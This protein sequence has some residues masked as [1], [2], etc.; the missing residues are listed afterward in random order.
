VTVI[1]SYPIEM[2]QFT[3]SATAEPRTAAKRYLLELSEMLVPTAIYSL[4][5]ARYVGEY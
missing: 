3:P 4:L 1:M 2:M 5:Y